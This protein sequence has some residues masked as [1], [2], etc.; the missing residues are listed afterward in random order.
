MIGSQRRPAD[1]P[2]GGGELPGTE[3][4]RVSQVGASLRRTTRTRLAQALAPFAA[5]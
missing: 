4:V 5:T 2:L 1:E 3:L